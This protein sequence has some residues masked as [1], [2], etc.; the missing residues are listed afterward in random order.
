MQPLDACTAL[1]TGKMKTAVS[2]EP[3]EQ[4]RW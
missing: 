3:R 4:I 2:R 1:G